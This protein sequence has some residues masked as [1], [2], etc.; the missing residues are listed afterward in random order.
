MRLLTIVLL[1]AIGAAAGTQADRAGELLGITTRAKAAPRNGTE[2]KPAGGHS[3]GAGEAHHD[4]EEEGVVSLTEEQVQA[5]GIEVAAVDAGTITRPISAPATILADADRLVHVSAKV[6][7]TVA[8]LRKR[9][10]DAVSAGDVLAVIESREV[11]EAKSELM[12]AQRTEQLARTVFARESELWRKRVSAEQDFLQARGAAEEARIRSDLARQKLAALGVSAAEI[13]ALGKGNGSTNLRLQEVR[14]PIAG[15]VI[16]RK[17]ILGAGTAAEADL[18]VI[19]D[20][21]SVWVEMSVPLVDLAAIKEGQPV[22]IGG[23]GAA[24]E[25]KVIFVSPM[26]D[27]ETRAARV[28][29]TLDNPDLAWRPGSFVTAAVATEPVSVDIVL[30]RE[31]VQTIEGEQVVFVRTE[32]GFEKREVVLGR[33]NEAVA[34]VVFGLDPGERIAVRNAFVLKAQVGKSEAGHSH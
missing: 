30:P 13:A 2:A 8:E 28:V 16:D 10:G 21:S 1:L 33:G 26:V 6:A 27:A 32:S 25:G 22:K 19:A 29:A 5:A 23:N 17:A 11:A 15:R 4:E 14:A 18:F 9:L 34:E 24:A 3:H 20:L 7:G 12:A 31:A